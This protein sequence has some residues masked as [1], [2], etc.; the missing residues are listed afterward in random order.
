MKKDL[1][2]MLEE[3]GVMPPGQW[4]NDDGP[5]GWFAVVD[6][7]GIIAYFMREEDAFF[8]RLALINATLNRI[9]AA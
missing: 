4:E 6:N 5:K 2:T 8:F 3:V 1:D 9:K 7:D